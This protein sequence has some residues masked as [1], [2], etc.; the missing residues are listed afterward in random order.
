MQPS[1]HIITITNNSI[2]ANERL[3]FNYTDIEPGFSFDTPIYII[4]SADSVAEL[5]FT[6]I[7]EDLSD[8]NLLF[9]D[10]DISLSDRDNHLMMNSPRGDIS[11]DRLDVTFCVPAQASTELISHMDLPSDTDNTAQ[12][13]SLNLIY[14]LQVTVGECGDDNI[15]VPNT[16]ILQST[17]GSAAVSYI[18]VVIMIASFCTAF[19]FGIILLVKRRHK[20][21]EHHENKKV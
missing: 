9:P 21:N 4:N 10:V 1:G 12:N 15:I 8:S 19:V 2:T 14:T 16:S 11:T 3:V 17:D 7:T 6:S 5:K 20:N 18:I 13:T